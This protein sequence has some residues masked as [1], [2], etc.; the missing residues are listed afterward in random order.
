MDHVVP[1]RFPETLSPRTEVYKLFRGYTPDKNVP[2]ELPGALP[3]NYLLSIFL[4][5]FS[6][7]NILE[8][9]A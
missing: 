2:F 1:V 7:L 4:G 3:S 9:W 8:L 5:L 6:F